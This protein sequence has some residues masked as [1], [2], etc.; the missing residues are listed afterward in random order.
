MKLKIILLI[1]IFDVEKIY[2]LVFKL[3][4]LFEILLIVDVKSIFVSWK[5]G[6]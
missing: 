5:L 4:V 1:E 3:W 6:D 2:K